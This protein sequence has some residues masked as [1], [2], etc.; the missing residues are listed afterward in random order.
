MCP[1]QS[2]REGPHTQK[3]PVLGLML[4]RQHLEILNTFLKLEHLYFCCALGSAHWLVLPV[5]LR[6]LGGEE[7]R[8]ASILEH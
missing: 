4:C 8:V 3:D 5:A 6:D 7:Q 2:Q 1:V